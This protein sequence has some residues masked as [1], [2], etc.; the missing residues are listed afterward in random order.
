MEEFN[1]LQNQIDGVKN[2][3]LHIEQAKEG[4]QHETC[5]CE[6]AESGSC[7]KC[8]SESINQAKH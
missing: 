6:R 8:F 7:E 2:R 4:F 3:V 1:H 5:L